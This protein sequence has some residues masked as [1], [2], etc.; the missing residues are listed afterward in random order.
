MNSNWWYY[1]PLIGINVSLP[2][3]DGAFIYPV[4]RPKL[5]PLGKCN[6]HITDMAYRFGC[7]FS[8]AVISEVVIWRNYKTG[9]SL[10]TS[11]MPL[12]NLLPEP[13]TKFGTGSQSLRE[14]IA[15]G[16]LFNK[17][18]TA[19]VIWHAIRIL[20]RSP[21]VVSKCDSLGFMFLEACISFTRHSCP[22]YEV[23]RVHYN[24]HDGWGKHGAHE[25]TNHQRPRR[26]NIGVP[27][28]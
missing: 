9:S 14:S 26:L 3:H 19:G 8:C 5:L 17:S 13:S 11:E 6:Y 15:D 20:P 27:S 2:I 1:L 21:A 7:D 4:I 22:E 28:R 10:M 18:S 16:V 12:A 23:E 25:L 24:A